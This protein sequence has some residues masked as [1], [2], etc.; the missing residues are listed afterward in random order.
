MPRGFLRRML[1]VRIGAQGEHEGQGVAVGEEIRLLS[2]HAQQIQRHHGAGGDEARQQPLRWFDSGR[3]GRGLPVPH[4]GFDEGGSR[5][6]QLRVP[7]Q[8]KA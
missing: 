7:G 4:A 2:H 5:R 8:I 3:T 1:P 6:R